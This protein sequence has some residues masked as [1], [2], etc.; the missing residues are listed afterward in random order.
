M[1]GNIFCEPFLEKDH[2]K[3]DRFMLSIITFYRDKSK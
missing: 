3:A 1:R 2:V